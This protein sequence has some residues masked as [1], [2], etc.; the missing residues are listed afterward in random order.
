[1]I[2]CVLPLSYIM[3]EETGFLGGRKQ[4][5]EPGVFEGQ[6]GSKSGKGGTA[7]AA[8]NGPLSVKGAADV[9]REKQALQGAQQGREEGRLAGEDRHQQAGSKIHS[10]FQTRPLPEGCPLRE[11]DM[12][13]CWA[14]EAGNCFGLREIGGAGVFT[15][16]LRKPSFFPAL[17][18]AA[19]GQEPLPIPTDTQ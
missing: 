2:E 5:G 10:V 13:V 3:Q 18:R 4:W 11:P 17:M 6:Q 1:M 19:A 8:G 12:K 15:T 7:A 16:Q 9:G 14:V